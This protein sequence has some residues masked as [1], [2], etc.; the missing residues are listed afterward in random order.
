MWSRYIDPRVIPIEVWDLL[1]DGAPLYSFERDHHFGKA[2]ARGAEIL[3]SGLARTESG[4]P[5]PHACTRIGHVVL[6]GG[7]ARGVRWQSD[8]VGA[9]S[10]AHDFPAERGGFEILCR[11]RVP[12]GIVIDLG[13]ERLKVSTL[14]Q[15]A[16]SARNN[17]TIP[18]ASRPNLNVG[19]DA[20]VRWVAETVRPFVADAAPE[21]V[22]FALPCAIQ[23]N[24][25]VS[26]CS[27][28]WAEGD[29]IVDEI[30]DASGL[31]NSPAWV[32][33]DAELAAIGFSLDPLPHEATLVLTIG[34]GV[35]GALVLG[36]R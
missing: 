3:R 19:R 15:R 35:G 9:T 29:S 32:V 14:N 21:G 8:T 16:M 1:V 11:H 22:V 2:L 27:Y 26:T 34:F 7:A 10:S 31:K 18:I 30:L 36:G 24:G 25:I 33:N 4:T 13:Q 28:P 20:L 5:F 6:S 17:N 23:H 12:N